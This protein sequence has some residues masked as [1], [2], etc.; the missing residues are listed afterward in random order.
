MTPEAA[1]WALLAARVEALSMTPPL[2]VVYVAKGPTKAANYVEIAHL[3]NQ[4][5][6]ILLADDQPF[7]RQG[8]LQVTLCAKPGQHEVVYAERAGLIAAHFLGDLR[9][10]NAVAAIEIYRADVAP[11]FADEMHWRVPVSVYYRS[12]S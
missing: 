6:R 3:P 7:H 5:S 1:V 9:S 8:I 2:P 4:N 11:G 12:Y 10:E